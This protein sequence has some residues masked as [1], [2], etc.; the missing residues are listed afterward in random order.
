MATEAGLDF[1]G[2]NVVYLIAMFIARE[3][4]DEAADHG[5]L[6]HAVVVV[7]LVP[8]RAGDNALPLL[9]SLVILAFD[10][11]LC[12]KLDHL[13]KAYYEDIRHSGGFAGR[14]EH[15]ADVEALRR[16]IASTVPRD[17][18]D[19]DVAPLSEVLLVL[20]KLLLERGLDAVLRLQRMLGQQYLNALVL[21]A[22]L[23]VVLDEAFDPL[24]ELVDLPKEALLASLG[25]RCDGGASAC[26][27]LADHVSIFSPDLLQVVKHGIVVIAASQTEH[28][29]LG[30][31]L[32]RGLRRGALDL[33]EDVFNYLQRDPI[34]DDVRAVEAVETVRAHDPLLFRDRDS[35]FAVL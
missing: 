14:Q 28:I 1:G 23:H 10:D 7:P 21:A 27:L 30:R 32:I 34:L 22:V 35:G 6:A 29:E 17:D 9:D 13:L 16:R 19:L 8:Y 33:V 12:V 20:L 2:A 31:V 26:I 15:I 24:L 4:H 5:L 11:R 3:D 25:H 18:F